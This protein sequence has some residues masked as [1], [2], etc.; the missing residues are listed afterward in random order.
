MS[1]ARSNRAAAA[2]VIL[3]RLIDVSSS[4]ASIRAKPL[5]MALLTQIFRQ[6]LSCLRAFGEV[7]SLTVVKED[8]QKERWAGR[9][10]SAVFCSAVEAIGMKARAVVAATKDTQID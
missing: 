5:G 2:G 1:G 9:E 3:R 7:C 4:A 8:G 10:R 6:A